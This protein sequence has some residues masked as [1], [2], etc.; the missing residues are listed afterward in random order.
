MSDTA[1]KKS[2]ETNPQGRTE[3]E[4]VKASEDLPGV[5][6]APHALPNSERSSH[7]TNIYA[8]GTLY[9]PMLICSRCAREG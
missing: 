1:S 9:M 3:H 7:T 8:F 4:E 6:G 2:P 5:D